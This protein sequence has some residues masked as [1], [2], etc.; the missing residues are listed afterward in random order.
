MTAGR[1]YEAMKWCI[2]QIIQAESEKTKGIFYVLRS[3]A[4]GLWLWFS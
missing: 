3:S 1:Y 2:L 4:V